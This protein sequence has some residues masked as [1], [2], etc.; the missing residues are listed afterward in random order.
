MDYHPKSCQFLQLMKNIEYINFSILSTTSF[1]VELQQFSCAMVLQK[2]QTD[3]CDAINHL[4]T[5]KCFLVTR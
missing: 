1:W 2:S 4:A 3:Y 5:Y